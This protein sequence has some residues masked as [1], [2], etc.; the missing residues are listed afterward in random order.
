MKKKKKQ[1]D[2]FVSIKDHKTQ[3]P[4]LP[5]SDDKHTNYHKTQTSPYQQQPAACI[6][7]CV[8][9]V[10]HLE[11]QEQWLLDVFADSPKTNEE[12]GVRRDD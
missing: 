8:Y 10:W 7:D 4:Y 1:K 3:Q 5:K 6:G 11:D 9:A 12:K 2:L